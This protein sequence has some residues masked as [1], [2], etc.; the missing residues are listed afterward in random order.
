MQA[1]PEPG[2]RRREWG[3]VPR[4]L[5]T[6]RLRGEKVLAAYRSRGRG[7]WASPEVIQ[8]WLGA[9]PDGRISRWTETLS[10]GLAGEQCCWPWAV[11]L[12]R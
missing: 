3:L 1:G 9:S 7:C 12:P 11:D 5:R 2:L 10:D 8:E 6:E 4:L